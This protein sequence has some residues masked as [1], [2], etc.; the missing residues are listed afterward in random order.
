MALPSCTQVQRAPH[1]VA[2]V[3]RVQVLQA[4][5]AL[6]CCACVHGASTQILWCHQGAL[7][8]STSTL[9]WQVPAAPPVE[10]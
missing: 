5:R 7:P 10:G 1:H 8:T 6:H 2:G 4:A 3:D 9:S